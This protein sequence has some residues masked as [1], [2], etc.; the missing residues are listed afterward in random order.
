MAIST[1][2]SVYTNSEGNQSIHCPVTVYSSK[3]NVQ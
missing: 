3:Y 1:F 2:D